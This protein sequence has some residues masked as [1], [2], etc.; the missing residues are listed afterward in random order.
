MSRDPDF[1]RDFYVTSRP[2]RNTI[3]IRRWDSTFNDFGVRTILKNHF[4]V[5]SAVR[6]GELS[7][8]GS[9]VTVIISELLSVCVARSGSAV[10]VIANDLLP[11]CVAN[12]YKCYCSRYMCFVFTVYS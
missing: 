1:S 9:A 5:S 10:T 12:L 3:N 2:V 4:G 6:A 11:V 7:A 8:I